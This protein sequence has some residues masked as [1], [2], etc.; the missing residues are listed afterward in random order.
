MDQSGRGSV[1]Q[2]SLVCLTVCISISQLKVL[3]VLIFLRAGLA[4][5]S[6]LTIRWIIDQIWSTMSADLTY[7]AGFSISRNF[8]T[9]PSFWHRAL[10]SSKAFGINLRWGEIG[11]WGR[12]SLVTVPQTTDSEGEVENQYWVCSQEYHHQSQTDQNLQKIKISQCL[13][14][15]Q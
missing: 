7:T 12:T 14:R 13:L 8:A 3:F 11:L 9:F 1:R 5:V 4:M 10:K 6:S 2:S 15:N